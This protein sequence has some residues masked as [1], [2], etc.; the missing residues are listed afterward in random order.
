MD[1]SDE[2]I[3][4][5]RETYDAPFF[6]AALDE[7]NPNQRFD[8]V[9]S[10]DVLYHITDDEQWEQS[11]RNLARLLDDKGIL[12]FSDWLGEEPRVLGDYVVHRSR[13]EYERV[14]SDLHLGMTAAE[15]YNFFDSAISMHLCVRSGRVSASS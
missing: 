11:L 4:R 5:A 14:L 6:L 15:P 12:I 2:A 10:M 8:A 7:F 9:I 13:R 1:G 3:R